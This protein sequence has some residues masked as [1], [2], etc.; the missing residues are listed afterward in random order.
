MNCYPS[1]KKLYTEG[2]EKTEG[3]SQA[4]KTSVPFCEAL[5]HLCTI[6]T[7]QETPRVL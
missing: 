1:K 6:P 3:H 4:L 5:S 7:P 2:T